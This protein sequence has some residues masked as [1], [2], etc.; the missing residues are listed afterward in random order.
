VLPSSSQKMFRISLLNRRL[1][2]SLPTVSP[3]T[4][5][6]RI[7]LKPDGFISAIKYRGRSTLATHISPFPPAPKLKGIFTQERH[8]HSDLESTGGETPE[9]EHR[10]AY[11]NRHGE[12]IVFTPCYPPPGYMFVPSGNHSL[13]RSCRKLAEKLYV[14]YRP[15]SRKRARSQIGLHVR[16]EVFEKAKADFKVKRLRSEETLRQALDEKYPQI[17]PADKNELHQLISSRDSRL[18]GKSVSNP[19]G[20]NYFIIYGYVRDKYTPFECL[21]LYK[22]TEAIDQAHK[23]VKEILASWRNEN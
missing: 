16:K 12:E 4:A 23:R 10:K 18:I 14:V 2:Q 21:D 15:E 11:T 8:F 9:K 7:C 17:P 3:N 1:L 20:R 22:D 5:R 19:N 6:S 13:T